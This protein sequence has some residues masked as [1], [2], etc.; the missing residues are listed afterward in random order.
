LR[1]VVVWDAVNEREIVLLS[2]LLAFGATTIAAL[3]KERWEI[4]VSR[5]GHIYQ[6]VRDQ[7]GLRDSS[8]VA[9]EASWRESKATEPSDNIL[10][11]SVRNAPGCNVQ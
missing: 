10:E 7:P 9:G 6:L 2:N 4:G 5:K 3:Y 8:L 11:R 1:R